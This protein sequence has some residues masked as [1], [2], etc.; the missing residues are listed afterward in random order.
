MGARRPE[1]VLF[2][3]GGCTTQ[4]PS[5][6][7]GWAAILIAVA[8]RLA[9]SLAPLIDPRTGRAAV[10]ELSGYATGTTSNRMEMEAVIRGLRRIT[11]AG[12]TILVVA[13]AVT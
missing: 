5:K 1:V 6:P 10:E 4:H 8:D 11:R 3:D 13:E 9:V 12:T 2:T 7:D